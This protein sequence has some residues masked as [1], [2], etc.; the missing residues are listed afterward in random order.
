MRGRFRIVV[1]LMLL[2]GTGGATLVLAGRAALLHLL[3]LRTSSSHTDGGR[4]RGVPQDTNH[5]PQPDRDEY[6]GPV[7][8]PPPGGD[9]V[10]Y[11]FAVLV[12]IGLATVSFGV[13]LLMLLLWN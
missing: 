9:G 11:L 10:S 8:V 3:A 5:E 12:M 13:V 7:N 1:Y 2:V 6:A 4:E